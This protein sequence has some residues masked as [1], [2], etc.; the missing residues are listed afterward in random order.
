MRLFAT[1]W[2]MIQLCTVIGRDS[3]SRGR[4]VR[5]DG[6]T[7]GVAQDP[8]RTETEVLCDDG[9]DAASGVGAEVAQVEVCKGWKK[10]S[11]LG[12]KG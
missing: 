11:E 1:S 8:A 4:K 9:S 10:R 5:R 3:V 6:R 7:E 2:M 12:R